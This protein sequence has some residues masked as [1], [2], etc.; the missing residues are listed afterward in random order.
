MQIL[1]LGTLIGAPAFPELI[2]AHDIG[3]MLLWV[4]ALLTLQTGMGYI[5]AGLRHVPNR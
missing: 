3:L 1:A 4:A 2:Y 5:I